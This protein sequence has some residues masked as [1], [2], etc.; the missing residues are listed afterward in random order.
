ME[1]I[2][3]DANGNSVRKITSYKSGDQSPDWN[4]SV[5]F[6]TR[7]WKKFKVRVYDSDYNADDPL[8]EQQT[9]TLDSARS[10]TDVRHNCNSGHVIFNYS[11]V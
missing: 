3:E 4:E 8:S 5:D 6:G 7:A 11:F 9:W 10:E 2:A 1:F